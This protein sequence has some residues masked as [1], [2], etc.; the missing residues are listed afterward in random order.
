[1]ALRKRTVRTACPTKTLELIFLSPY[2]SLGMSL[3]VTQVFQN[4]R[5]ITLLN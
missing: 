2:I 3:E 1:M 4:G 5:V